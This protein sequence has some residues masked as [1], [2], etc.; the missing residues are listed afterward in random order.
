MGMF[1]IYCF[2]CGN[3]CHSSNRAN[4]MLDEIKY[5][6]E[7]VDKKGKI[8]KYSKEHLKSLYKRYEKD[9]KNFAKTINK[10]FKNTLW[11]RKCTFLC[12]D[13]KIVHGCNEIYGDITFADKKKNKYMYS[14]THS[15]YE[16]NYGLF[17]HDDCWQFV[18]KKYK[19][20]LSYS[21]IPI[22][23]PY[24][25]FLLKRK[26]FPFL[27]YGNLEK[28]YD[29]QFFDFTELIGDYNE[30]LCESPFKSTL[31]AKNII[32]A[33]GKLKIRADRASPPVSATFYPKGTY[34]VGLNGNIWT[35]KGNKWIEI[36]NTFKENVKNVSD[37]VYV[38]DMNTKPIFVLKI[39]KDSYDILTIKM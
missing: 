24:K 2:L 27:N 9:P 3:T 20:K 33:F 37:I 39:N 32:K 25:D 4:V 35:I 16:N 13:N 8:Y 17:V 21:H 5:Y 19:I 30:K 22:V 11:L 29:S 6:E 34:K 31:V 36:K 10:I 7:I 15:K 1:D 26:I 12:A 38:G 14:I 23:K 18:Y 28:Y